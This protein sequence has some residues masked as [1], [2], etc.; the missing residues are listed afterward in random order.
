MN[1]TSLNIQIILAALGIVG[2][3]LAIAK[4]TVEATIKANFNLLNKTFEDQKEFRIGIV[5]TQEKIA[6]TLDNHLT[7]LYK[8]QNEL[9]QR[10]AVIQS[11]VDR[12]DRKE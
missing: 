2:A 12:L 10:T 8:G 5:A 3:M 1:L 9:L 11:I 4:M 6:T 7:T